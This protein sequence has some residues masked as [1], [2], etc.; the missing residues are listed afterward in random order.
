[1]YQEIFKLRD[2]GQLR[3]NTVSSWKGETFNDALILLGL[4]P[5][6]S[7]LREIDFA[8]AKDVISKIL[9]KDLAYKIELMPLEKAQLFANKI[10]ADYYSDECTLYTNVGTGEL[11]GTSLSW[12]PMTKATFDCG[13]II[14]HAD[15]CFCVWVEDED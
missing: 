3:I 12:D 6:E 8:Y 15:Y 4:L 10:M 9:W 7:G 2:C 5:N 13:V 14:K 11:H 1:M